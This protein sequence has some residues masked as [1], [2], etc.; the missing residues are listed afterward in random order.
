MART[1]AAL[2]AL[3]LAVAM[4]A[5]AASNTFF[6]NIVPSRLP[7]T[8]DINKNATVTGSLQLR[9]QEG[10]GL[11]HV[12]VEIRIEDTLGNLY[13]VVHATTDNQGY[14][15][16]SITFG[17]EAVGRRFNSTLLFAGSGRYTPCKGTMKGTHIIA[18][19]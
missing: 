2:L 8:I 16:F 19:R 18:S 4:T 13:R 15:V 11:A 14:A 17:A 7:A 5:H 9:K 10:G 6:S 3:W 1:I 12:P